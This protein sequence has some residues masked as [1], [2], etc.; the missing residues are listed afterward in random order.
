MMFPWSQINV[1]FD[2][3]DFQFEDVDKAFEYCENMKDAFPKGWVMN[4]THS[5][6]IAFIIIFEVEGS[7]TIE[8]GEI[9]EALLRAYKPKKR[10][11]GPRKA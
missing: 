8:D 10:K 7:V 3:S 4:G 1:G 5:S 11:K 6:P 9:V 2:A